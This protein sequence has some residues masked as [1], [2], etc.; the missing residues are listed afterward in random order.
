MCQGLSINSNYL[1]SSVTIMTALL[2]V[3]YLRPVYRSTDTTYGVELY[4]DRMHTSSTTVQLSIVLVLLGSQSAN[5][6]NTAPALFIRALRSFKMV[7]DGRNY[8]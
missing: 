7:M 3:L 8:F 6:L 1:I 2:A 5:E 4:N